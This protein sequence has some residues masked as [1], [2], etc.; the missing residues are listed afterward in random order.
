MEPEA[1][2]F[3]VFASGAILRSGPG[4]MSTRGR[5]IGLTRVRPVPFWRKAS[6]MDEELRIFVLEHPQ[7]LIDRQFRI[8]IVY[9]MYR[10]RADTDHA[11]CH[12]CRALAV[13]W[14]ERLD[15]VTDVWFKLQQVVIPATPQ[16]L[17]YR[18]GHTAEPY[19]VPGGLLKLGGNDE[20]AHPC[21]GQAGDPGQIDD[22]IR[23][24][25]PDRL[26]ECI[27]ERSSGIEIYPTRDSEDPNVAVPGD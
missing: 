22:E 6:E 24:G 19:R 18:G 27:A 23:L 8:G 14:R 1:V 11:L 13:C 15:G 16:K 5:T 17:L 3:G 12:V 21:A 2:V 20:A 26:D 4:Q 10:Q 7:D 9:W 25:I